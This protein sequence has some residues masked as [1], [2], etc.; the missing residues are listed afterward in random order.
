MQLKHQV[1]YYHFSIVK[2]IND[3]VNLIQMSKYNK[4]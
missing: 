1:R 2:I 4:K 3:S